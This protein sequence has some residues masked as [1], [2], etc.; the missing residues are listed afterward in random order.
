[1]K[2]SVLICTYNRHDLLQQALAALIEGTDEKPDEVIVVNG[3]DERADA[4]VKSFMG[5]HGIDLQLVKTININ[6]ATSRN[7]GL[8]HCTGDIVAMT[9]DDA[10][11]FADWITQI[12]RIHQEHPEAGGVGGTIIGK[13]SDTSLLSRLSDVITFPQPTEPGYLRT[14]P[15]V[16]VSYKR[17]VLDKVGSQ[18][19]TLIRGEDVDFNWRI[20]KLGYEIYFHPDIKVIHHHR[21]SLRKFFQQHYMYGRGYYRVRQKWPEMYCVYPHSFKRV[22]DFLKAIYFFVAI[23]EDPLRTAM[24]LPRW[25]DKFL[26]LPILIINH[27][28]WKWGMVYEKC[29]LARGITVA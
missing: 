6:L 15:G 25:S 26:A 16:N 14:I 7:V 22:K 28:L 2:V 20:K 27:V 24:K 5:R 4:V 3:G 29:R 19:V 10:E 18:D 12:K 9:D 8:E 21:P 23:V 13:S 1:V 11:V 17:E